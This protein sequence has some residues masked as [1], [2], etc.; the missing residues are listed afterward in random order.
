MFKAALDSQQTL[1]G[2]EGLLKWGQQK[3]SEVWDLPQLLFV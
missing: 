3:L 1:A 2:Q